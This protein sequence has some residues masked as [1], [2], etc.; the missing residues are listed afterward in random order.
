MLTFLDDIHQ[1]VI[2]ALD[3]GFKGTD[4]IVQPRALDVVDHLV[5][6]ADQLVVVFCLGQRLDCYT[7]VHVILLLF[8]KLEIKKRRGL[9]RNKDSLYKQ[10]SYV[11][12]IRIRYKGQGK[13]P[14]LSLLF[15]DTPVFYFQKYLTTVCIICQEETEKSGR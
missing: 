3:R 5:D 11:G 9:R 12:M 13:Q 8:S 6:D 2:V 7:C 15:A 1:L 10:A 14:T 4:I